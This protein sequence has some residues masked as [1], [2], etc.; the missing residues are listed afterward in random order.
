MRLYSADAKMLAIVTP[1][2]LGK[3]LE[4]LERFMHFCVTNTAALHNN[5]ALRDSS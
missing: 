4:H 2:I 1:V 3:S 5:R